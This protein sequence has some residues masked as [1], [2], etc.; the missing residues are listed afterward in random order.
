MREPAKDG[1]IATCPGTEG[2]R[3]ANS[4]EVSFVSVLLDQVGMHAEAG[5]G[6]QMPVDAQSPDGC[7]AYP[8]GWDHY[9]WG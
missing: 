6:I 7:W 3:A 1:Y 8:L 2:Y 9:C 5:E 4:G